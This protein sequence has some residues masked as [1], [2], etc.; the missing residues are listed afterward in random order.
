[1]SGYL[2]TSVQRPR[3]ID[4]YKCRVQACP[5]GVH[6]TMSTLTV[7]SQTFLFL[8]PSSREVL[9]SRAEGRKE[10]RWPGLPGESLEPSSRATRKGGRARTLGSLGS[11][12]FFL[13]SFLPTF[14]PSRD[15]WMDGPSIL[16]KEEGRAGCGAAATAKNGGMDADGRT[17]I[18]FHTF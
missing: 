18:E 10:P 17:Y 7:L 1:M 4:R 16:S 14:G 3:L 8:R 12:S 13:P 5:C 15:G 6:L 9:I 2:P 11:P